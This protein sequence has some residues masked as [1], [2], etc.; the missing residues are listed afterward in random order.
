MKLAFWG[1]FVAGLA[2]CAAFGIGSTLARAGGSWASPWML[3]GCVLGTALVALAVAFATGY[4]PS[5]LSTDGSMVVALGILL[6]AK[7]AV[8]LA[9]VAVGAL[10]RG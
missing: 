7:V 6:G 8:S 9:Q 4:H 3:A 1:L 2:A 5:L 10:A